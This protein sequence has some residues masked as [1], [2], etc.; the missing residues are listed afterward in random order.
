M[1]VDDASDEDGLIGGE[2]WWKNGKL[3]PI[4]V[5]RFDENVGFIKA[6]NKG[7][8]RA[9]GEIKVLISNDVR[10]RNT[11][12]DTVIKLLAENPNQLIGNVYHSGDTGWNKF[13]D[14]VFP[15]LSGHFL[16][17]TADGWEKL[18]YFD[19]QY[20]PHCFEDID[21]ST[22]A[23]DAGY[24]LTS[25]HLPGITHEGGKTIRYTTERDE[26]TRRNRDKFGVKWMVKHD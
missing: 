22:E 8:K 10:V 18:G 7:L 12:I 17:A 13:D 3:L 6:A 24:I 9:N 20:C 26:L 19:E 5:F 16:C 23:L 4:R 15:Y 25:L 14:K 2:K 21:L 1:L 11:F